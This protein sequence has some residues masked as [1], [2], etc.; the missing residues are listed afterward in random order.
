MELAITL[1]NL[2]AST[3]VVQINQSIS[4]NSSPI[5]HTHHI[6]YYSRSLTF[7]ASKYVVTTLLHMRHDAIT[8]E[9]PI[10]IALANDWT[11]SNQ[12][13]A[14]NRL[15]ISVHKFHSENVIGL[16]AFP[17]SPGA[18]LPTPPIT[19]KLFIVLFFYIDSYNRVEYEFTTPRR[20]GAQFFFFFFESQVHFTK[21][22]HSYPHN[23]PT[24]RSYQLILNTLC[25]CLKP[26]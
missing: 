3:R 2:N 10:F 18:P 16:W 4:C 23:A 13:R 14:T 8:I 19:Q 11:I 15:P 26:K 25:N 17:I 6:Y 9:S 5:S 7:Y 1:F 20:K 12:I 24:N 22:A 21:L